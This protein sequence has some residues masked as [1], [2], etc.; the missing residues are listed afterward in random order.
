MMQKGTAIVGFF[1][2]FVAGMF[3]MYGVEK[4][5]GGI[6]VGKDDS[7]VA[8]GD[9][10]HSDSP[11][12]IGADD[13]SWGNGDA[14]VT[15][16]EASDF[17]CPFCSRVG[18]TL[19]QIKDTY[20]PE[21][22]RI[23]WK[24]NPLPFHKNAGPAHTASQ[25]AFAVGGSEA[26]WK[27]H[28]LAFA[29]Q[30][31]LTEENYKKWAKEIGL[32]AA[33][34]E[35]ALKDPKNAAKVQKDLA[36]NK[37]IGIT[38]TPAF[39][40]N[41][42]VLSGAQP[43]ER[44]KTAIDEQLKK[45]DELVKAGTAKSQISLKLT[46]ENF[47]AA[48]AAPE[49][50]QAPAEDTA[51]WRV[52][53]L[54]DDPIK[55]NKDALVTIVEWSDFQCP[56]CSRVN[57]TMVKL[58]EKYGDDLRVVW[59]DNALPFHNEAKPAANIA[60]LAYEKGG[61]KLF[62]KAHD[63]LFEKQKELGADTYAAIAKELGLPADAPKLAAA[64]KYAEKIDAS[65]ELAGDLNAR[66]TPH[67]FVNGRRLSGAQP[68]EK[69]DA[70]VT[71]QLAAAKKLLATGVARDKVYDELMKTA[72]GPAAPEK[73]D[74]AEPTNDNPYKGNKNGKIVI[75]EFSDFECP[76]CSRVKPTLTQ[77]LAENS[78]V[79]VVWRHMPLPFHKNAK[80]ASE[81]AH[82]AFIQKGNDVFWKF[83]DK[84]F[85]NQKAMTREDLDKYAK[86]F[87]LD[88]TKFKK[89]LDEG[90]HTKFVEADMEVASKAGVRG[91]PAFT[92]NG[93]FISGAQPITEFNKMIKLAK[94][95][96]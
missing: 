46:K 21:K 45:A 20:G 62:W 70:L 10:D 89:A 14:L 47:A 57:P 54:K 39:R 71:E 5:N 19:K 72:K 44:F 58:F 48:P 52:P 49:K 36:E 78:D 28:D 60:R 11:I 55:G 74:V 24:H 53:V 61:D 37:T 35:A 17:E 77:I 38:G 92:V 3:L 13:A 88:M 80:L 27:F 8:A 1:L 59:K 93:Y 30:K 69:F 96:K 25:A 65:M 34:F 26:F 90:K 84:L 12:K 63:L 40:I 33:K 15:I 67:F 83:H 29:N 51:T 91:T 18:G 66:G 76:Y 16:I 64:N 85:E 4:Y 41:G 87:G 94:S 95:S 7:A 9:A 82:E 79:K 56:F 68:F 6:K 86:E 23:V 32:D 22:V 75:Q 81:A 73:K 31:A 42:V 50:A 43:F 2:S